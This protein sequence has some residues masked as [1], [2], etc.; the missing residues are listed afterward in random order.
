[1]E[2]I[3]LLLTLLIFSFGS[4]S[5]KH[6]YDFL[7]GKYEHRYYDVEIKIKSI[8][9]GVKVKGIPGHKGWKKFYL[10][11]HNTLREVHG[12]HRLI[13]NGRYS[14]D[15]Q[16]GRWGKRMRFVRIDNSRI[17]HHQYYWNDERQ[18]YYGSDT[19]YRNRR[20]NYREDNIR[21]YDRNDRRDRRDGRY[22]DEQRNHQYQDITGEWYSDDLRK[23]VIIQ[24]DGSGIK[25]RLSGSKKWTKYRRGASGNYVDDKGNV[26]YL[27]NRDTLIW[28]DRNRRNRYILSRS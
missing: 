13:V 14:V 21:G 10:S 2:K 1:M 6:R 20:G 17:K 18:G 22:D 23:L 24:I 28:E 5:A 4:V 12:N 9:G 3:V 25:A 27:E 8:D 15:I 19:G 16:H 11:R 26:Y 7:E